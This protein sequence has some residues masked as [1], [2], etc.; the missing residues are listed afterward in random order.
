MSKNRGSRSIVA[1]DKRRPKG[2][3]TKQRGRG[4]IYGSALSQLSRDVKALYRMINVEDKYLDT[5]ATST[6]SGAW[7]SA[8]LNGLS[9]GNT[10]S[11]RTGQSVKCVGYEFRYSLSLGAAAS[12][13]SR[14]LI[15]VDKQADAA[16]PTLTQVFPVDITS[17]RV[18]AYLERY[19]VLIEDN[20]TLTTTGSN[21]VR[22]E[23]MSRYE[24]H[25]SFNSGNAGTIADIVTNSMYIAFVTD[26][27]VTFPSITYSFR[28]V[29][30][31]N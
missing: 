11:Q 19:L 14:I 25:I 21:L 18:V 31:D 27:T 12:C 16:A 13:D 20:I 24:A 28:F 1:N 26:T 5:S 6:L 30:V 17:P 15:L 9:Q 10:S 3:K 8:L 4:Q 2:R 23:H 22:K 29:Y 7:Q